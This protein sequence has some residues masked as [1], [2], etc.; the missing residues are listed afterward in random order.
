[1]CWLRPSPPLQTQLNLKDSML[2]AAFRITFYRIYDMFF[3][4]QHLL[5]TCPLNSTHLPETGPYLINI[6]GPLGT[7]Y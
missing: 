1:M 2:E 7:L 3:G 6:I 4:R 5:E